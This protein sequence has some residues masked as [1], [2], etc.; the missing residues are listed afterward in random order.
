[1]LLS[2]NSVLHF[3][4]LIL[5]YLVKTPNFLFHFTNRVRDAHRVGSDMDQAEPR[6]TAEHSLMLQL[7]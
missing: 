4:H 3:E 1:M 6:E 5:L 2:P 7:G